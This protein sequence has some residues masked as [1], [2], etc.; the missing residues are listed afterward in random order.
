[1]D[2]AEDFR[3][4]AAARLPALHRSAVML[5]GDP[6]LAE[7]LVQE[8]LTRLYLVWD[9]GRIN[10]PV[11]Y[12]HTVLTR[13]F[14]TMIRR[15]SSTERAVAEVHDRGYRD[16]D[17]PELLALR[18]ALDGLKPL[19][20][21]IVVLRY[22]EDRPVDE[23]AGIVRKSAGNVRVRASRA[24]ASMRPLLSDEPVHRQEAR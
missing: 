24:L 11:A 19:D 3:S 18:E 1:M 21:A 17:V 22:L 4:F 16:P 5:C 23:V 13:V 9:S 6:Y 2:D 10:D 14:L 20:R 15:R 12:S 8:A 7:D